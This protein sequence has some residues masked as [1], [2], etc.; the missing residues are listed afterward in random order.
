M[1]TN[2]FMNVHVVLRG[3]ERAWDAVQ[4]ELQAFVSLLTW[5]QGTVTRSSVVVAS[6][7]FWDVSLAQKMY[8]FFF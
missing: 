7:Y 5:V 3:H 4:L 2:Y 8:S 6:A 1:T